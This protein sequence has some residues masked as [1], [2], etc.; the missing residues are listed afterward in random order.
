MAKIRYPSKIIP[1]VYHSVFERQRLF[2]IL[3]ENKHQPLVWVHGSPGAGKT[4]LVSSWLK[5]RQVRFLWYRMDSGINVSADLFYFLALSAQRNY[6]QKQV[7]L[8]AFTAEYADDIKAFAVVF[9]RR[10]FAVLDKEVAIVFDN[11]QEIEND[12][13]FFHVLQIALNDIP[14][15]LQIIC[16]S[17]NHP[18]DFFSRL[19]LVGD[20]LEINPALL[21]FTEAESTA[22]ISWL[23]PDIDAQTSAVL[24]EKAE[25]WAVALVLLSQNPPDLQTQTP[26]EHDQQKVF[27]FLMAEILANMD[28]ASLQFLAKTAVFNQFSVNMAIALTDYRSAR[29][30]LNDL[31][32]NNFLIDRTDETHPVYCYHPILRNLLNNQNKSLFTEAQLNEVHH[33][34]INILLEQQKIEEAIPFYLQLQDWSGL[35]R[36]LLEHSENFINNGRHHAVISWIEYLPAEMLANDPWLLYWYAV[37]TKPLAPNQSAEML[38]ICYQQ[39]YPVADRLGLYSSWQVAVEAIIIGLDGF[40][41]LKIWFQRFEELREHYPNCPS[42]ELKI[43]FSATAL[44]A[45]S[46][47][48]PQHP[49]YNKLLKISEYG[50]R[51]V[52]VKLLQQLISSY[53][54]NHYL[55]AYEIAKFQV[56]EPYLLAT[57]NDESLPALPRILNANALSLYNQ[58]QGNGKSGLIYLEKGLEI[59]EQSAIPLLKPLNKL[60]LVASHICRGDLASAQRCL[61]STAADIS[62]KHR[63]LSSLFHFLSAWICALKGQLTVALEQ[64]EQSLQICQL[65]KH[66]CGIVGCLGLKTRLLAETANWEKAE[67]ALLLLTTINQKLPNNFHQ[68]EYHLSYAWLEFL[69]NNQEQ[70]L[71]GIKQFLSLLSRE[72]MTFFYGWQP[73]VITPLCLLAI[74]HG[75]EVE[76]AFSMMQINALCPPPPQHLE[77]WPWPVRIYCFNHLKIELNGQLLNPCGKSQKKVIELLWTLIALGSQD[78]QGEQLCDWLW[79]DSDGDLAKQAL[80]TT[81]FRLRKLIGKATVLVKDGSISLNPNY[82]WIDVLAFENTRKELDD[83]LQHKT[84]ATLI[85]NKLSNRLLHLYQGPFLKQLDSGVVIVKQKQL[86]NKLTRLSERLITYY[87]RQQN[88]NQI[89][90]LIELCLDRIPQFESDHQELISY[91]Q[92]IQN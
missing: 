77:Q 89:S 37:A 20:L 2:D 48:N 53:L 8:P 54:A 33:K 60:Y 81:L 39:F 51:I 29:D 85:V 82:C 23:N 63:L 3:T 75:I 76:F 72:Q 38:D 91:Y 56:I 46:F 31:V 11:C 16:I 27:S 47:Y 21:R 67:H 70:A 10:L 17:R 18:A 41:S 50:L 25:G 86:Q 28:E 1:P 22:F 24:Q 35:K 83:A 40:S 26:D 66:D 64:I 80:E 4:T 45:L 55:L 73:H 68:L 44:Q 5:Q 12:P 79:P 42:F 36:L 43:K 15:G 57:I 30:F 61:D 71:V 92:K 84:D 65:I 87:E 49:W 6:P 69:K 78:V 7:K 62:S 34:A 90:T 88:H 74:E 52:P 59:S 9:F 19:S 32:N 13:D 58:Y 14:E